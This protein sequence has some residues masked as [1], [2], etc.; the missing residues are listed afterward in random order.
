MRN[1]NTKE[2]WEKRFLQDWKKG[3]SFQTKKYAEENIKY[4]D[5]KTDFNGE[6]LD[7]G[8]ALGDAIPIYSNAFPNA[9]LKG[10]DISEE[11]IKSCKNK[12]NKYADFLCAD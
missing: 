3:G 8:C 6:I 11:A 5:I 10:V 4:L 7:F 2:Y 1:I 9:R 12:Y